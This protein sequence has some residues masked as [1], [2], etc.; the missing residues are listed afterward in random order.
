MNFVLLHQSRI[1]K[2]DGSRSRWR[3]H[4]ACRCKGR[5]GVESCGWLGPV[6]ILSLRVARLGAEAVAGD[7]TKLHFEGLGFGTFLGNLT[8]Y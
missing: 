8:L 1:Q 7:V 6:Q 4:L 3:L 2:L 5:P